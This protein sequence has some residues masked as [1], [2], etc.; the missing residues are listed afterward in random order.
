MSAKSKLTNLQLELLKY[1]QYDL[2]DAQLLEIKQLLTHYFAQRATGEMDKMWD[3]KGWNNET[4]DKWL[5]EH[6]RIS[7]KK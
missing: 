7:D 6:T 5:N 4:M 3:E 1:F 2:S